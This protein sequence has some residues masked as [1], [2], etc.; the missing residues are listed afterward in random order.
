VKRFTLIELL[1]VVAIIGILASL[2]MP[3]LQKAREKGKWAV[4]VNNIKQI[5]LGLELYTNDNDDYFP[6]YNGWTYTVNISTTKNALDGYIDTSNSMICP[7]DKGDSIGAS[8]KK[9]Y[10]LKG[11]SYQ[12]AAQKNYWGVGYIFD[13]VTPRTKDFYEKPTLKLVLGDLWHKNRAW[14]DPRMQWHGG[15]SARR[16]NMLFVDGHVE[17]FTFPVTYEGAS[18]NAALDPDR[19]FH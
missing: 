8:Q 18:Q 6:K 9:Y 3:S 16:C 10:E 19:G 1:V 15:K 5:G 13:T 12:A 11:T 7:S 2:L 4:C 14:N 17:L